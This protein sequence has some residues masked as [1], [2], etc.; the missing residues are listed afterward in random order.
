MEIETTVSSNG[1]S[2]YPFDGNCPCSQ[3]ADLTLIFDGD[4]APLHAHS[5]LLAMTSPVLKMAMESCSVGDGVIQLGH[6]DKRG[7]ILLL[8]LLHPVSSLHLNR[9]QIYDSLS[10]RVPSC[11]PVLF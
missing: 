6:D 2:P 1:H 8:N 11:K 7:W 9:T 5:C 3:D 4:E 10:N